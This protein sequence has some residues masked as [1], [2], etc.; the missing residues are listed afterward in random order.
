MAKI[1]I[2]FIK[3]ENV[4]PWEHNPRVTD[5]AID[6]VATSIQEHGFNQPILINQD[7][8]I[9]C[10]HVRHQAAVK[11]KM[12]YVPCIIKS[13]NDEEF[14]SLNLADNKS[15]SIASWDKKRRKIR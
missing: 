15:G 1:K 12:M 6:A 2:E 13:M 5:K 7:N 11:L 3:T 8:V 10:G 9:C 14:R 4:I